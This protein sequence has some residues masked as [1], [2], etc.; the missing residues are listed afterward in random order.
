MNNKYSLV[1]LNGGIGSRM[2]SASP[3]QF[4][5]LNGI[6]MLVYSLLCV[7]SL[8]AIDEIVINYPLGYDK[9]IRAVIESYAVGKVVVYVEA[10]K[11]RQESV[12]L[13]LPHCSNKNILL[14]ETARPLVKEGDF[15]RLIE[16]EHENVGLM[17]KIPFA[18][19][20]VNNKTNKVLGSFNKEDLRNV[21]LPQKFN[22][23]SLKK[24]HIWAKSHNKFYA[25]DA[26]LCSDFGLDV[27]FIDG[28]EDNIKITTPLDVILGEAI[29][30]RDDYDG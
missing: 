18:V 1:L 13:M 24:A 25:D 20:P 14:H 16:S 6:P 4:L 23:E 22:L 5:K 29:L 2:Q 7:N 19:V 9:E 15:L 21:Q 30:K 11:T 27:R 17:T 10:G 3:K 28:S 8:K 12:S 26:S